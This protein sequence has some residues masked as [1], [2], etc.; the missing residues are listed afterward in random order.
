MTSPARGA[1]L[2]GRARNAATAGAIMAGLLL[3]CP[4]WGRVALWIR[5]PLAARDVFVPLTFA[6]PIVLA[7]AVVLVTRSEHRDLE[8]APPR[9]LS[10]WSTGWAAALSVAAAGCL[11]AGAVSGLGQEW[12]LQAGRTFLFLSGAALV[13]GRVLGHMAALSTPLVAFM[14]MLYAAG[15]HPRDFRPWWLVPLR[16]ADD[17]VSWA[18]AVAV[19]VAG[20]LLTAVA[21]RR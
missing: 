2:C 11:A 12:L 8:A 17:P 18:F 7:A 16:A 6:V 14:V 19:Y 9:P 1:L 4:L 5:P 21:L 3:T 13:I 10:L 15:G 20:L